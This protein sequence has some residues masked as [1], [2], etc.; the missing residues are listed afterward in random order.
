MKYECPECGS[1]ETPKIIIHFPPLIYQCLKC[2]KRGDEQDFFKKE[3]K[4][5]S[6]TPLPK[7]PT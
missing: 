2:G 5:L 7:R 1:Q 4:R 6:L 3:D